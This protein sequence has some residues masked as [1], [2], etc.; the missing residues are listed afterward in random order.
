VFLGEQVSGQ[1][2]TQINSRFEFYV[3]QVG[4]WN[5]VLN[6]RFLEY[7]SEEVK[8]QVHPIAK[9]R[10]DEMLALAVSVQGIKS[11]TP[12]V[13]YLLPPPTKIQASEAI[14]LVLEHLDDLG[15]FWQQR[16]EQARPYPTPPT[17]MPVGMSEPTRT[18]DTASLRRF[19]VER[20]DLEELR[21]LCFDLGVDYDGL[22]G[23]GKEAKARELIAYMQRR[24]QLVGLIAA[25]RRERGDIV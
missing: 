18:L 5:F 14:R 15:G 19:L 16:A 24:G 3:R 25:I 11:K 22:R 1:S 8:C 7:F 20:F 12:G 9:N 4:K 23:E 17:S 10:A 21:T 6:G 2:I 13:L